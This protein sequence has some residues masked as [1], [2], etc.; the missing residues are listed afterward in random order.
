MKRVVPCLIV[1]VFLLGILGAK[2][3][4]VRAEAQIRASSQACP[5]ISVY[6]PCIE[7]S[8]K[9][10]TAE[11]LPPPPGNYVFPAKPVRKNLLSGDWLS[12]AA[13]K[14]YGRLGLGC[15]GLPS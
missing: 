3:T 1:A 7:F 13:Q 5:Q 14:P 9:W 2:A 12:P 6:L 15:G 10:D 11:N 4:R 8:S